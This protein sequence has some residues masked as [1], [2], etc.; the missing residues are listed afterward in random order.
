M[1]KKEIEYTDY[2]PES[3]GIISRMGH[4]LVSLDRDQRPNAMTIGWGTPGIIWG[5]PVF[6]VLV[7]PSRY[8]FDCI[9]HTGDF[10]VNVPHKGMKDAV[11]YCGTVSGRDRDKFADKGL[12][13][14]QSK[15]VKSPIIE[16]CVLHYE[17]RVVHHNDLIPDNL[18]DDIVSSAY[19]RG[20]FHRLYFGQI[21]SVY[22][23]EDCS[24]KLAM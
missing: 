9:E 11:A 7:R 17:C 18:T 15:T 21:L 20:D 6:I 23:D 12:T 19:P 2:L 13:A 14:T 3:L 22:A 4:L 16:E 10:T 5:R 8:T 1:A 24:G